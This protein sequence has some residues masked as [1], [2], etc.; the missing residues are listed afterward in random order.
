MAKS[1]FRVFLQDGHIFYSFN[2]T[3]T[4]VVIPSHPKM[5]TFD[6][7][8]RNGI[9]ETLKLEEY[10]QPVWFD[11]KSPTLH[12]R[13]FIPLSPSF[14]PFPFLPL[15]WMPKIIHSGSGLMCRMSEH[16]L[17]KWLNCEAMLAHA[18]SAL[19][20]YHPNPHP[21]PPPYPSQCR[22]PA[23]LDAWYATEHDLEDVL[24]TARKYFAVWMGYLSYLI[25]EYEDRPVDGTL[26]PRP[27][28]FAILR[29]AKLSE[30]WICGI[31]LSSV[32]K[33][34]RDVQRAG[35]VMTLEGQEARG[36]VPS[37]LKRDIPVWFIWTLSEE[38]AL[39]KDNSVPHL[40][41]SIPKV[42]QL[43]KE[44][45][46]DTPPERRQFHVSS[47]ILQCFAGTVLPRAGDDFTAF[48]NSPIIQFLWDDICI[49]VNKLGGPSDAD[50]TGIY[51]RFL[52]FFE[53]RKE[54]LRQEL[55]S[56][57]DGPSSL[58]SLPFQTLIESP[59]EYQGDLVDGTWWDF[60]ARRRA[61]EAARRLASKSNELQR[62]SEPQ[63]Y[64]L[65]LSIDPISPISPLG[66][67]TPPKIFH[68]TLIRTS[69]GKD[70]FMRKLIDPTFTN[71]LVAMHPEHSRVYDAYS[72]EL[73]LGDFGL[74]SRSGAD[75]GDDNVNNS[76]LKMISN[77]IAECIR[78]GIPTECTGDTLP[79]NQDKPVDI[80][81]DEEMGDSIWI[82]TTGHV[83]NRTEGRRSIG[84]PTPVLGLADQYY[85][86]VTTLP[87]H[88]TMAMTPSRRLSE[89]Y[90][91][92]SPS[93]GL[94]QSFEHDMIVEMDSAVPR[95]CS[96]PSSPPSSPIPVVLFLPS[97]P[98]SP[99]SSTTSTASPTLRFK[100][101]LPYTS[102]EPTE[103]PL[104]QLE[105]PTL[106]PRGIQPLSVEIP[107]LPTPPSHKSPA[108]TAFSVPKLS[109]SIFDSRANANIELMDAI[110]LRYGFVLPTTTS[111]TAQNTLTQD[112]GD[113]LTFN[114]ALQA[115]GFIFGIEDI[116]TFHLHPT[117]SSKAAIILFVEN[118]VSRRKVPQA[119]YDLERTNERSLVHH[120]SLKTIH[121]VDDPK[122]EGESIYILA[123]G[124][125]D[126][127]THYIAVYTATA[128]L[129]VVRILFSINKTLQ[130]G[131]EINHLRLFSELL[132]RRGVRFSV[133]E[134]PASKALGSALPKPIILKTHPHSS[135]PQSTHPLP[136]RSNFTP[137]GNV[138]TGKTQVAT[139]PTRDP[140]PEAK[141]RGRA[142]QDHLIQPRL[143]PVVLG[144][145]QQDYIFTADDYKEWR[146]GIDEYLAASPRMARV[147]C[148]RGGIVW[149]VA[150]TEIT[151][152][153]LLAFFGESSLSSPGSS[154]ST[155]P[156]PLSLVTPVPK[157]GPPGRII[158][159]VICGSYR[160]QQKDER[161]TTTPANPQSQSKPTTKS[162]W[163]PLKIWENPSDCNFGSAPEWTEAAETFYTQRLEEIL[164]GG[165][166]PLT[167]DEWRRRLFRTSFPKSLCNEIEKEASAFLEEHC[168]KRWPTDQAQ[169]LKGP[170]RKIG[171]GGLEDG[172]PGDLGR[173]MK[174]RLE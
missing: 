113:P 57:P 112:M 7:P 150:A 78:L 65:P 85:E 159:S 16:D 172:M 53:D 149:R 80:L 132:V 109:G 173:K 4:D 137:A 41:P 151:L 125:K 21:L 107:R 24:E 127:R 12:W 174:R 88:T 52:Q 43:I 160:I 139:P 69:G 141:A 1:E 166:Q 31:A 162:W 14:V 91:T 55:S 46:G 74:V 19:C 79:P 98:P 59:E 110:Y 147:I 146:V 27:S 28:W 34:S 48:F 77:G 119:M 95:Q 84:A 152:N 155:L 124:I 90:K 29:Q 121:R 23:C 103:S 75:D 36:A 148:M 87:S 13:A 153:T 76:V 140:R 131:A 111:P 123:T 72:N 61:D 116:P 66:P 169:G 82:A 135:S 39:L 133:V 40:L 32:Y 86:T 5:R 99:S 120:Y 26:P 35:F 68:W 47:P 22:G 128:A 60:F 163:P 118:K 63:D 92:E 83:S 143:S 126:N 105:T 25:A 93:V 8:P 10:F 144:A 20:A 97:P 49:E 54:R 170:K 15:C 38:R 2:S 165:G 11:P 6:Q 17:A 156:S 167:E 71:A 130:T 161:N 129:F 106:L 104:P 154:Q 3:F 30:E 67:H 33:F 73:D 18:A 64:P 81:C 94:G 45:L 101:H 142:R 58:P 42:G 115:T 100:S 37:Y 122:R 164:F 117:P 51:H 56:A 70:V 136:S 44:I 168:S 138:S 50:S 96:S 9:R 134:D 108:I 114:R 171:E 89:S 145:V 157:R 62:D 102:A 158:S